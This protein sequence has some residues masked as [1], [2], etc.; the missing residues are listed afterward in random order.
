MCHSR[1]RLTWM[2]VRFE[3]GPAPLDEK[4]EF[5]LFSR[6]SAMHNQTESS[7]SL[8]KVEFIFFIVSCLLAV[9]GCSS[10]K[11][12]GVTEGSE[13]AKT[14]PAPANDF[15]KQQEQAEEQLRPGIESEREK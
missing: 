14:S 4:P 5:I 2:R 15:Q 7:V 3:S 12:N 8:I 1:T 6:S 11:P 13:P 10:G 9:A